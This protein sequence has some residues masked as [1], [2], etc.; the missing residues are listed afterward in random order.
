MQVLEGR[1]RAIRRRYNERKRRA[2]GSV[3]R[4]VAGLPGG[5]WR[6]VFVLYIGLFLCCY[7]AKNDEFDRAA[8]VRGRGHGVHCAR[9][10]VMK[11]LP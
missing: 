3:V 5:G 8:A 1:P 10:S 9:P 2:V 6:C 7:Y 11:G 4:A